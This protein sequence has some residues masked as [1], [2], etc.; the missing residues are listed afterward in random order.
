MEVL[1]QTTKEVVWMG[2]YSF[3]ARMPMAL[4]PNSYLDVIWEHSQI[5][6][7][8]GT[9]TQFP[10]HSKYHGGKKG[11]AKLPLF[12]SD[13]KAVSDGKMLRYP[14]RW[15]KSGNRVVMN[16]NT[17]YWLSQNQKFGEFENN[18]MGGVVSYKQPKRGVAMAMFH[19]YESLVLL[20]RAN[21]SDGDALPRG[22]T[23]NY[24]D[25]L[26]IDNIKSRVIGDDSE[27]NLNFD[28]PMV[29]DFTDSYE[30]NSR[31]KQERWYGLE[32]EK[33]TFMAKHQKILNP[34]KIKFDAEGKIMTFFSVSVPTEVSVEIEA[35]RELKPIVK[36]RFPYN[37]SALLKHH[38]FAYF[39]MME[40][41]CPKCNV[42]SG[43]V[44]KQKNL[45]ATK[46]IFNGADE[47]NYA[48]KS[49]K[50][51]YTGGKL[52]AEDEKKKSKDL[53][54]FLDYYYKFCNI[55]N[56]PDEKVGIMSKDKAD[57]IW[58]DWNPK[59]R[60]HAL[61]A[62]GRKGDLIVPFSCEQR[63][64]I[65]NYTSNFST[66]LQVGMF[67]LILR[68]EGFPNEGSPNRFFGGVHPPSLT[69]QNLW[70]DFMKRVLS[71]KLSKDKDR[72]GVESKEVSLRFLWNCLDEELIKTVEL[73]KG[74][75][76]HGKKI[77]C[78]R[79][80]GQLENLRLKKQS[81]SNCWNWNDKRDWVKRQGKL[82]IVSMNS[83]L[84]EIGQ[85]FD[86]YKEL[87]GVV[88][89]IDQWH[90]KGDEDIAYEYSKIDGEYKIN[91]ARFSPEEQTGAR[92]FATFLKRI[93]DTANYGILSSDVIHT[94]RAYGI[95][96]RDDFDIK[97]E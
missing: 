34:D 90:I 52:G 83:S 56:K 63:L 82:P 54:K 61:K 67:P 80:V 58:E 4:H 87:P 36:K 69:V 55:Y 79:L 20:Q 12:D 32:L 93:I 3:K 44:C 33:R 45:G 9:A 89:S 25:K 5:E 94:R 62:V 48:N 13:H 6:K 39:R 27:T 30:V 41:D 19:L 43:E 8:F 23:F 84:E 96:L 16:R 17:T 11:V 86:E 65:S 51:L 68:K 38:Q 29:K 28:F 46:K 71:T 91:H 81:G 50:R 7:H 35:L 75:K 92:T 95:L 37:I 18:G 42:V 49:V 26:T 73:D 59:H 77:P 21:T 88:I 85:L 78:L 31:P 76:G 60:A 1:R 10:F 64:K 57:A 15:S 47:I 24:K 14:V 53:K 66:I 72:L 2:T 40:G 22:F 97:D 74:D 70:V